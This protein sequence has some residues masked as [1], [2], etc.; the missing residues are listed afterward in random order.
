M[1]ATDFEQAPSLPKAV[2]VIDV[3]YNFIK[4]INWIY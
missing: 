3:F 4:I 1:T 2:P